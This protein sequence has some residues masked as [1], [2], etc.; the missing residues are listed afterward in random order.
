MTSYTGTHTR[1]IKERGPAVE[2]WCAAHPGEHFADDWSYTHLAEE[3]LTQIRYSYGNK[4]YT[5]KYPFEV[6][7]SEDIYHDYIPL[8]GD[9]HSRLDRIHK[10]ADSNVDDSDETGTLWLL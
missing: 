8:S 7:F 9:C 5:K 10:N 3:E 2:H 4:P 6:P 1:L